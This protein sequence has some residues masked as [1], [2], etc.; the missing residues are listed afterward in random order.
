MEHVNR[1]Q[2]RI[3]GGSWQVIV[4]ERPKEYM[5]VANGEP[6]MMSCGT[7]AGERKMLLL[8]NKDVPWGD[9]NDLRLSVVHELLHAA[10]EV[11]GFNA[12]FTGVTNALIEASG[13]PGRARVQSLQETFEE[14][15]DRAAFAI[16][17]EGK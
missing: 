17:E 15:I 16:I 1:Y 11:L 14:F 12:A 5:P 8:V 6:S 4:E 13:E 2:P 9:W 10:A 3:L 7:R